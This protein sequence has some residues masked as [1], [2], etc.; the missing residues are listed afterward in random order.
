LFLLLVLFG[1]LVF[2]VGAKSPTLDEQNH[3][4]RG[5]AYLKTG[6][7]RLS[8]EHPPGANAWVAWPLLLDPRVRLPLESVSW[9]NGEWYGFADQLLWS[10]GQG[11]WQ[12]TRDSEA[13]NLE[14]GLHPQGM[15]FATRVPVMWLTLL[16]AALAYRWARELGGRWAGG[17]ALVLLA[18]DPN[19]LAHGRLTTNDL[20]LT[21]ATLAASYALWRAVHTRQRTTDA[22]AAAIAGAALGAA[23]LAKFSA[24]VL[25]PIA[26]LVL[27]VGWISSGAKPGATHAGPKRPGRASHLALYFATAALVVWAGYGFSWGPI[28][29][30]RGLPGPAPAF[31]SG[32]QSILRRTGGGSSAFLLGQHSPTG[33][34]YYFPVAFAVKTPLSTLLLLGLGIGGLGIG[35]LIIWGV[36]AIRLVPRPALFGQPNEPVSSDLLSLLCLVLS[37]LAFWA[38]AIAGS[39]NIGYRHILPSLPF[40]YILA[41]WSIGRFLSPERIFRRFAA[42]P[43]LTRPQVRLLVL[44][45][46]LWL[47]FQPLFIAPHY[48]A[49]F[50][51]LA[52]GP[53][54]GY[55][56]LVD[57]NL[58]WGQDLPGLARTARKMGEERV[59]LS[60]FG[61]AHPE[62]YDLSF[63]PLPGFWRFGGEA[64][65]YGFNPLAP[66]PGLYAI[67]ATNLQGVKL[68]DRDLYAWFRARTPDASAGHSIL[69]YRVEPVLEYT[70]QVVLGV[71]MAQLGAEERDLLRRAGSVRQYDPGTGLIVPTGGAPAAWYVSPLPPKGAETVR[72]GPGYTLAQLAEW[73]PATL[74]LTPPENAHFGY[75]RPLEAQ[76]G[77]EGDVP[78]VTLTVIVRWQ[79]DEPPHRAAT[80][81]VHLL[82]AQGA[83]LAGWDG[84]TAPATCWQAG[85]RIEQRYA[86]A[87]PP[88]LPPDSYPIEIGWYEPDTGQR[89]AYRIGDEIAGDRW[90]LEWK[91]GR[92]EDWKTGR[93]EAPATSLPEDPST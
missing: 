48:L 5:L 71:P 25:V 69:L 6:D 14:A 40:L 80:S 70:E 85:D 74:P 67:S 38:I 55:R 72:A 21:S 89:W 42:L 68:S 73:P 41:A 45:L 77:V 91:A 15:V 30:L 93:A 34:W 46:L 59:Y 87:L 19:L 66:A 39:F 27:F 23:L 11:S 52:G 43:I 47:A 50:N 9:A 57:S 28:D 79:V 56:V 17:V 31:W 18:F 37:P 1:L 8:Q 54:N 88:D 65:A 7:L 83:Y 53:Q 2:S 51:A 86:I 58:D 22:R 33:W 92:V 75:V 36:G 78:G 26:A 10:G 4:A 62:A 61:A 82:D 64:A 81:F 12:N 35:R 32:I 60:W 13:A 84:L 16:L 24:L 76:L 29:A 49:F 20:G 3:L 44:L 90:L 63:H